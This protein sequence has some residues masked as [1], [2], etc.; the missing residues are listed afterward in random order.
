M[1]TR[2][3]VKKIEKPGLTEP[4]SK[5]MRTFGSKETS[6]ARCTLCGGNGWVLE[7]NP[8]VVPATLELLPCPLPDCAGS[9]KRIARF[10]VFLARFTKAYT[11]TDGGLIVI[12]T[13]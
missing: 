6:E 4:N 3:E 2:K 1:P 9:A 10:S 5:D 8:N 12:L 13:W 7:S 11:L